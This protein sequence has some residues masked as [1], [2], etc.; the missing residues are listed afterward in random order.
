CQA[1]AV[2]LGGQCFESALRP[3]ATLFLASDACGLVGGRLADGLELRALRSGPGGAG[4]LTLDALGEWYSSIDNNAG[5][6]SIINNNGVFNVVGPNTLHPF[7][8]VFRALP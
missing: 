1:G 8:C 6:G 4:F 7:R 5:V 3:V 2:K